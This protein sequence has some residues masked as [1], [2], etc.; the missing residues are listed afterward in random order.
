M[1][2]KGI[3]FDF[4]GTMF[5]DG[6][7][8]EASWKVFLSRKIGR[9]VSDDEFQKYVHG[10]NSEVSLAY[11]LKRQLNRNEIDHLSEKK[12]ASALHYCNCLRSK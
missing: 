8:Q 2:T 10:C 12:E 1:K 6:K 3:I 5:Y 7:I 4:N 11:F 9:E